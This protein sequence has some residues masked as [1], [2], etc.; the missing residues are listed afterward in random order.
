MANEQRYLAYMVRL[1]TVHDN[2][3]LV[4]RASVENAHTGERHAFAGLPGLF[5]FMQAA[6]E[7][8]VTY[9]LGQCQDSGDDVSA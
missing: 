3:Y 2:G 9:Q 1:W 8:P 4:W 6:I 7:Q 5:D